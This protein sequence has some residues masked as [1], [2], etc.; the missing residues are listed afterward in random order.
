MPYFSII[1]PIYNVKPYLIRCVDSILYQTFSDFEIIL[2]DDGSTDGCSDICDDYK[3]KDS[4][5]KVI[6]KKNGG[7]SS[8]RNAGLECITGEYVYFCDSDDWIERDLLESVYS[9]CLKGYD[10]I[11]FGFEKDFDTVRKYIYKEKTH[12]NCHNFDFICNVFLNWKIAWSACTR[13]YKAEIIKKYGLSFA[14]NRRIFAED[15]YFSL[16]FYSHAQ[17]CRV[18]SGCFYHYVLRE[19]SIMDTQRRVLN[20]NRMNELS[21]EIKKHYFE[22]EDCYDFMNYYSIIHMLIIYNVMERAVERLDEK[23]LFYLI[24]E[25]VVDQ[26][27][28][29]SEIKSFLRSWRFYLRNTTDYNAYF[30][31]VLFRYILKGNYFTYKCQKYLITNSKVRSLLYRI[32]KLHI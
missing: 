16:V 31:L 8:A 10:S 15:L 32:S 11:A 13:V 4:R 30:R 7:L 5:V 21:K 3:R 20:V 23:E 25:E 12:E 24:K 1:V 27:F 26:K 18:A 14:D 17:T 22:N 9:E 6:H 29:Y 2:V 19:N 28:F